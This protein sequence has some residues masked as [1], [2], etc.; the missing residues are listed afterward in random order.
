MSD[1]D[2]WRESLQKEYER[3]E[4]H[5]AKREAAEAENDR[6]RERVVK[7]ER[8]QLE[9]S[10]ENN[11]LREAL[12]KIAFTSL[13]TGAQ[14]HDIAIEALG[15]QIA[16]EVPDDDDGRQATTAHKKLQAQNMALQIELDRLREALQRCREELE[17]CHN[18]KHVLAKKPHRRVRVADDEIPF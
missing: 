3:A 2:E 13:L 6:L 5:K 12:E 15:E 1:D 9:T 11:R 16:V 7:L 14:A 18:A 17:Q 4:T 10:I 8:S